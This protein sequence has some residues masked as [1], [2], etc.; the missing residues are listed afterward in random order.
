MTGLE[1]LFLSL[2]AAGI[3]LTLI[4]AGLGPTTSDRVVG[5]D[6]SVTITIALMVFLAALFD[7]SIYLD[8]ALVYAVLGFIGVLAVARYMERGL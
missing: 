4:R 2:M 3:A 1:L 5:V 7:R 6:G 8:V